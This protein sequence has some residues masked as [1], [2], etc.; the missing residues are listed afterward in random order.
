MYDPGLAILLRILRIAAGR[1]RVE[2]VGIVIGLQTYLMFWQQQRGLIHS[3]TNQRDLKRNLLR[4][5]HFLAVGFQ[6]LYAT[7]CL[8]CP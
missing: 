2:R 1:V 7:T 5:P 8:A 6:L 3:N 4:E